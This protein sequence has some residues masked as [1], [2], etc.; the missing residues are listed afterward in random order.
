MRRIFVA[1]ILVSGF[2]TLVAGISATAAEPSGA[3]VVLPTPDAAARTVPGE[4]SEEP[5]EVTPERA[6]RPEDGLDAGLFTPKPVYLC[7]GWQCSEN[8]QCGKF[9]ECVIEPG[10]SCGVCAN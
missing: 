10:A 6:P 9:G 2:L 4:S 3:A 5:G 7:Y 8:W 1:I